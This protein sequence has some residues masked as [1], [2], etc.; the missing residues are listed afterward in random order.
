MPDSL[1]DCHS[2]RAV[3][4]SVN[5]QAWQIISAQKMLSELIDGKLRSL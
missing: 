5:R 3:F 4:F 1:V 2:L